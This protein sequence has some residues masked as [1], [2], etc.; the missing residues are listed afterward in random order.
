MIV[1]LLIFILPLALLTNS[2]SFTYKIKSGEEAYEV[3]QY[4]VAVEMLQEEYNSTPSEEQRAYLA[5]LAGKSYDMMNQPE[6]ASDWYA[7]SIDAGAGASVREHYATSLRTQERYQEAIVVYEELM[8]EF[9]QESQYRSAIAQCQQAMVWLDGARESP[10]TV[11][12]TSLNSPGSDYA[13]Y[14]LNADQLVFTSDRSLQLG[15]AVYNW[16]GRGFSNIW[17]TDLEG[18]NMSPFEDIFN[19]SDNEGTA[20]FNRD[21]TEIYFSRCF[22]EAE[23]DAYCRL[24]YSEKIGGRWSPPEELP[25]IKEDINYGHP[26]LTKDDSTLIYSADDPEGAGG[27]DL[28]FARRSADGSW[29]EPQSMGARINSEG[30][31]KFPTLHEDTLYFS[32]DFLPGMGGLDIF[33][34][35]IGSNGNWTNPYNLKPPLNSGWDDFSFVVDTFNENRGDVLQSGYFCSSRAGGAGSDDIYGFVKRKPE[36]P[37]VA[38]A[39]EDVPLE[40]LVDYQLFLAIKV[41]EPVFEDPEDP[42]SKRNGTRA[43]SGARVIIGEGADMRTLRTDENGFMVIEI[44]YDKLYNVQARFRGFLTQRLDVDAS[45]VERDPDE[46]VKTINREIVLEPIFRGVEIVLENIYYDL[47]KWDI[48]DDAKPSLNELA[49]I[50]KDNPGIRIQLGSHTDCRADDDYNM[51]LSQKRAQSAVDYLIDNGIN[52]SRLA[53]VGYGETQFAVDCECSEC[54]EDEHQANRRTTFKVVQ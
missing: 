47:D 4:A 16:T 11:E 37:V 5:F 9:G 19:T 49:K 32:S 46:P 27:Y 51:D 22:T 29:S 2:C 43:L 1:R 6:D 41:S 35:Y 39:E 50:L 15:D 54:T 14:M 25:F 10:Y 24:M 31:E 8:G 33:R 34:T 17:I 45:E 48:R 13:P 44:Q 30:D 52:P 53:A 21:R 18:Y 26:V 42:N 36:E 28:Y 12:F 20:T 23:G 3:K 40:D 7:R 38:D